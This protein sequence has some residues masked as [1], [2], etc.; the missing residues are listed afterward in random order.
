[1]QLLPVTLKRSESGGR[2]MLPV[3]LGPEKITCK[4]RSILS[5]THPRSCRKN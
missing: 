5:I 2:V 3:G 4:N 1:M